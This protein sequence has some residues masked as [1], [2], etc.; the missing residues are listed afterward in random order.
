MPDI[1]YR[2]EP[3][4]PLGFGGAPLGNMFEA[5]SD[6]RAGDTMAAAWDNGIRYFDTAPFY[7][8]GLSEHRFGHVL[9]NFDRESFVLSTKV[10]RLLKPAEKPEASIFVNALPFEDSVEAAHRFRN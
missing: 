6:N 1:A 8:M 10:G 5:V 4:G 3:P 2:F 9:R 7:G